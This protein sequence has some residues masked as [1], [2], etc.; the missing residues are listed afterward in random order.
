MQGLWG[1]LTRIFEKIGLMKPQL[2]FNIKSSDI[3]FLYA[4]VAKAHSANRKQCNFEYLKNLPNLWDLEL[5]VSCHPDVMRGVITIWHK[6]EAVRLGYNLAEFSKR[7]LIVDA[8]YFDL[9]DSVSR[10]TFR[11]LRQV[12]KTEGLKPSEVLRK[13]TIIILNRDDAHGD[14]LIRENRLSGM[15]M[16]ADWSKAAPL[17]NYIN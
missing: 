12:C 4:L 1:L 14:L 16:P 15:I 11:A 9:S 13:Y 5:E 6:N 7:G 8:F 3:D 10:A 17:S 2:V